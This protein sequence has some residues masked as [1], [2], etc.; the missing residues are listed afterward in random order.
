MKR[1]L[2]GEVKEYLAQVSKAFLMTS[3]FILVLLVA[4]IDYITGAEL[5]VSIFYLIPISLSVLFVN[6]R[7]GVLLSVLSSAVGLTTD[8]MLGHPYSHPLIVY[9]N[10]A[11]QMGFFLIIVFILSALKIE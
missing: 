2:L 8:L 3:G 1:S 9:W 4:V 5:S 7:G 11:I 6:R 10:N